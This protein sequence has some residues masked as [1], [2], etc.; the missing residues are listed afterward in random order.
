MGTLGY[1]RY[2]KYPRFPGIPGFQE[3]PGIPKK[4]VQRALFLVRIW[5][6]FLTRKS[7]KF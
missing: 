3:F 6:L 5:T 2:A 4:V 1:A 7:V